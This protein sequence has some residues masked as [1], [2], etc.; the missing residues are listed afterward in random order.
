MPLHGYLLKQT[1]AA[2]GKQQTDP[3]VSTL[4]PTVNAGYQMLTGVLMILLMYSV[5]T[6]ALPTPGTE[7]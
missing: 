3:L 4:W 7:Q 6:M 2:T 1:I 5:L